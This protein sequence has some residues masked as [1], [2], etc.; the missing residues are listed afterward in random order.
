MMKLSAKRVL[1]AAT[2]FAMIGV[3][4]VGVAQVIPQPVT[5]TVLSGPDVGFRVEGMRGD[6]PVG[7][8]VV[9][10][11]GRWVAVDFNTNGL[12]PLGTR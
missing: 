5:P 10:V 4:A 1:L 6:T 9:K 11:N 3:G 2:C 8:L 12:R 7:T